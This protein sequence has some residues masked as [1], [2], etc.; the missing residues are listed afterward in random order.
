MSQL[1]LLPEG[2]FLY[3]TTLLY[4]SLAWTVS[5][6]TK[7][8]ELHITDIKW[9]QAL[10]CIS[11]ILLINVCCKEIYSSDVDMQLFEIWL[12]LFLS[13]EKMVVEGLH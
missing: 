1:A 10:A 8:E 12:P 4:T 5:V 11:L 7:N 3:K 9:G 6:S 13:M 2:S